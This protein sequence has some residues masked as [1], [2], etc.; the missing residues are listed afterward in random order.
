MK[1]LWIMA[2]VLGGTATPAAAA[3]WRLASVGGVKPDRNASF[4]YISSQRRTGS[5]IRIW[6]RS[7][8]E[9][10]AL[11][12]TDGSIR[13]MEFDC[14]EKSYR[15][16]AGHFY[17]GD[18]STGDVTKSIGADYAAPDSVM[19]AIITRTCEGTYAPTPVADPYKVIRLIWAG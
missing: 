12:G 11:D 14:D 16:V 2:A 7:E 1:R 3:D 18:N 4:V 13:L 17:R 10:P 19:D 5:E 15:V 6:V 9:K 8:W